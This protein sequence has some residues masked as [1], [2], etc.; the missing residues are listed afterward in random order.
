MEIR[1]NIVLLVVALRWIERIAALI[2]G[3]LI[4][5]WGFNHLSQTSPTSTRVEGVGS[6]SNPPGQAAGEMVVKLDAS[7]GQLSLTLK[8]Y[9]PG[10]ALVVLGVVI[11]ALPY[12]RSV[13]LEVKQGDT[14]TVWLLAETDARIRSLLPTV[15]RD[16]LEE[17]LVATREVRGQAPSSSAAIR[18]TRVYENIYQLGRLTE[19]QQARMAILRD[20]PE[21]TV[22]ERVELNALKHRYSEDLAP[23]W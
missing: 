3:A 16:D 2:V 11:V 8:R 1:D 4:V 14:S 20:K 18:L 15:S 6:T 9:G 19:A 7:K 17:L 22:E 12:L 13:K 21:L 23:R 5:R 10:V